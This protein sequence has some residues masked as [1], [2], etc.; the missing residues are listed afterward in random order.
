[1]Y[2]PYVALG[3][4]RG[5]KNYIKIHEGFGNIC[6]TPNLSEACHFDTLAQAAIGAMILE[7][8][9]KLVSCRGSL[10]SEALNVQQH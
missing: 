4:N 9:T 2:G 5:S 6:L 10:L 8:R 7:L 3:F 1:M